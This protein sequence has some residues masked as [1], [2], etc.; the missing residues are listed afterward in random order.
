MKKFTILTLVILVITFVGCSKD[1]DE[2]S[3]V[4]SSIKEE[5]SE[6]AKARNDNI[7]IEISN[8]EDKDSIGKESEVSVSESN[9]N[10]K[11]V[12]ESY[13]LSIPRSYTRVD[14]NDNIYVYD[15]NGNSLIVSNQS[16]EMRV[17][18]YSENNYQ[19]LIASSYKDVEFQK[20]EY[21]T[22]NKMKAVRIEYLGIK[23]DKKFMNCRY[24]VENGESTILI[25]V[26]A[27]DESNYSKL[28]SIAED[29]KF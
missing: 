25:D 28:K 24:Y 2:S 18:E 4:K 14:H 20:F 29:I 10:H 7:S 8:T 1:D 11:A 5:L 21:I 27:I 26:Q 17:D 19:K 15:S 9:G 12:T 6:E 23:N 13:Q 3:K 22:V 16:S